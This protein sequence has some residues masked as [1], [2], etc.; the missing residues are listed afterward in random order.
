MKVEIFEPGKFVEDTGEKIRIDTQSPIDEPYMNPGEMSPLKIKTDC[1]HV[2]VIVEQ[3]VFNMLT[4]RGYGT[5]HELEQLI[6]K[7]Y[8]TYKRPDQP[9]YYKFLELV[10]KIVVQDPMV[11][12]L[13]E[14]Q[15]IEQDGYLTQ[16]LELQW[17]NKYIEDRLKEECIRS[18]KTRDKIRKMSFI[19]RVFRWKKITKEIMEM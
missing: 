17:E 14:K 6:V 18:I 19:D 5:E 16:N 10:R 7:G 15:N 3:R 11:N 12:A 13:L 9:P 8:R 2:N 1:Y 4:E